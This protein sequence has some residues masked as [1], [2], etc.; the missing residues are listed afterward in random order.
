MLYKALGLFLLICIFTTVTLAAPADSVIHVKKKLAV[1][2]L[3]NTLIPAFAADA[4]AHRIL[5][6]K[7]INN[8]EYTLG[9]GGKCAIANTSYKNKILQFSI[10]ATMF[11]GLARYKQ[12]GQ[13]IYVDYLVD[14]FADLKLTPN[15]M[16]RGS[17]GH[18][19]HH[20]SDDAVAV[21]YVQKNYAKDYVQLHTVHYLLKKRM[22]LYEG[23]CYFHNFKIGEAGVAQN[24][25]GNNMLQAGFEVD[26]IKINTQHSFFIAAD[27]KLRQELDWGNTRSVVLGYKLKIP[28]QKNLR[29]AYQHVNGYAE[30][31]QFY[32]KQLKNNT[33]GLYVEF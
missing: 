23:I 25:S 15:F 18:T 10:A 16:L 14:F 28:S 4:R 24:L 12:S 3:P 6:L 20:L 19:S 17:Y 33:I 26:A 22:M 13:T 29:I 27:L 31:G 21:G 1:E 9:F 7:D 8:T 11:S 30:S 2:L 32:N 5:I